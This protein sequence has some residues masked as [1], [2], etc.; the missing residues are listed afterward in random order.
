MK[1][2]NDYEAEQYLL[3]E[4]DENSTFVTRQAFTH[5]VL[6]PCLESTYSFIHYVIREVKDM[7]RDIQP[8]KVYHLGGPG[9]DVFSTTVWNASKAC[10]MFLAADP[11]NMQ[12]TDLP[13]YFVQRVGE[14]ANSEGIDLGLWEDAIM[15]EGKPFDRNLLPTAPRQVKLVW[16][17]THCQKIYRLPR[18]ILKQLAYVEIY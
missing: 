13:L 4:I 5:N 1:N 10:Q 17:A 7:H 8:L 3:S 6:N 15:S 14:I 16:C 12:T 9:G 18:D 11:S 2:E